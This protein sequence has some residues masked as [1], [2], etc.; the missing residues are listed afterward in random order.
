M[1]RLRRVLMWAGSIFLAAVFT[2]AGISKLHG[3]EALRWS[4]RFERWGYPPSA[5]YIV[6][7]LEIL[8]ALGLLIPRSR[9]AAS[10]ALA[11]LMVGA[12]FTHVVHGEFVRVIPPAVLG[13]LACLIYWSHGRR[14]RDQTRGEVA[15]VSAQSTAAAETHGDR[16]RSRK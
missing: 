6:G 16:A 7:V 12:L 5:S 8:G 13:G 11:A 15:S 2:R 9:P 3:A 14:A 1:V 4:E 10:L